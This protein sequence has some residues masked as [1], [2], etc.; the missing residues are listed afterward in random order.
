MVVVHP[1]VIVPVQTWS[2]GT[3]LRESNVEPS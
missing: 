2:M 1:D 3:V